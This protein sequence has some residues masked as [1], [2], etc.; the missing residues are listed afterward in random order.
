MRPPKQQKESKILSRSQVINQ[1]KQEKGII[2]IF[3]KSFYFPTNSILLI[4]LERLVS[5]TALIATSPS[6]WILM[7]RCSQCFKS[8]RRGNFRNV[9]SYQ[10]CVSLI[11]R[12]RR[13]KV[14]YW[15]SC[16]I[17]LFWWA[18]LRISRNGSLIQTI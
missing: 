14:L 10:L 4:I 16:L 13:R 12:M 18:K 17:N 3:Y 1:M 8:W 2:N 5:S 9:F 7:L 6:L 15:F 11:N